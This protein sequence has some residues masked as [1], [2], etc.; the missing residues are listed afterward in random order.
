MLA[1]AAVSSE[2]STWRG[3]VLERVSISPQVALLQGQLLPASPWPA[4]SKP[5]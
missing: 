5:P 3:S 4:G 2:D 1:R